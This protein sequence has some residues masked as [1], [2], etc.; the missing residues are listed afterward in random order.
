MHFALHLYVDVDSE[1]P[2]L[3]PTC[4]WQ[5]QAAKVWLSDLGTMK[6]FGGQ[7]FNR[8]SRKLEH[9]QPDW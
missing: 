9:P 1:L 8:R 4:A 7:P 5:L 6:C 3:P 2:Q